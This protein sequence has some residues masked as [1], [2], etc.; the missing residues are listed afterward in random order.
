[1]SWEDILNMDPKEM[2]EALEEA[3]KR[4]SQTAIPEFTAL[5]KNSKF[6][7]LN[8]AARNLFPDKPEH[9]IQVRNCYC[10]ECL[11]YYDDESKSC[12]FNACKQASWRACRKGLC[13]EHHHVE[14][15]SSCK[16]REELL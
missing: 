4:L 16:A 15:A 1:M 12:R 6:K 11:D 5:R 10:G 7:S 14:G 3:R 2:S 8:D 9:C 13:K